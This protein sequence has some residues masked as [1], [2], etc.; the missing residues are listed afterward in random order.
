MSKRVYM[1]L[2]DSQGQ[3]S[4][5]KNSTHTHKGNIKYR[6]SFGEEKRGSKTIE[7]FKIQLCDEKGIK[8]RKVPSYPIEDICEVIEG[9]QKIVERVVKLKGIENPLDALKPERYWEADARFF[10]DL[11]KKAQYFTTFNQDLC[12]AE[13]A[14]RHLKNSYKRNMFMAEIQ[15][16]RKG[17]KDG[18]N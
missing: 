15:K 6:I 5:I 18:A 8:G 11:A 14:C 3:I 13:E 10:I 12:E 16:M 1:P 9:L 7:V 4:E 2:K 17:N